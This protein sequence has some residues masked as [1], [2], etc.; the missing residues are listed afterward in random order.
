M[1]SYRELKDLM[2]ARQELIAPMDGTELRR[3]MEKQATKVG[4]RFEADLSN[5][6]LDDVQGEPGAMPLL[7]HALRELWKRRH[8]RWLR[9]EEYRAWRGEE[10]DCRNGGSGV[11]GFV[12]PRSGAHAGHFHAVNPRRRRSPEGR[13][14]SR[15]PSAS[16]AGRTDSS[17]E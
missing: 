10:G 4:L 6:I 11:S 7:Q 3:A 15:Y 9:A 8:G 2:Q 16:K 14:P 17:S 1:R 5:T 13:G 12:L